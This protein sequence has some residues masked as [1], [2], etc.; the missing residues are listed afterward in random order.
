M[1][2]TLPKE[3]HPLCGRS[4]LQHVINAARSIEPAQLLVVLSP[5]KAVVTES[6]PPG[7]E[8]A[9]QAEPLGT[10]HA[11][12]QALPLLAPSI[13]RV[14]ILYGDHPLLTGEAVA[15][16]VDSACRS[17]ALITLLTAVLPDPGAYGRVHYEGERVVGVIEAKDDTRLFSEP[18]EINSGI[19]CFD[20]DWLTRRLPDV[21]R[22]A[23]GEYYLTSLIE[24]AAHEET[25]SR[26]VVP[27]VVAP[28]VAFGVN[29]RVELARAEQLL[30]KRVNERLM[31]SGVTIVDPVTT[32]IDDE[33]E[34]GQDARI[35]PFTMISGE[36]RIGERTVIGPSAHIQ[37]TAIG[38]DCVILAS[39]LESSTI[40]DR[41]HVGPYSHFRAGTR[42]AADVHIGNYVE[43][44]SSS[45][46]SGT[47]IGHFSYI[48]DAEIGRNVNIAAGTITANY[49]GI[50]KHRTVI[51]DDAFIGCDTI[52]RAPVTVG[53]AGRTG[54]G[55]VVT[56]DVSPGVTVV[57]LPARPI[58]S[59]S[60][61]GRQ[62]E[63][64]E[65]E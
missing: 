62:L 18:V 15:A 40:G 25:P 24:L 1:R 65:H 44:K 61:A 30:R 13:T 20:R 11:V 49:D 10:G 38:S 54:A 26:P 52:L 36:S 23:S 43:I 6:L 34:I 63:K 21:P 56:R 8:V 28:E 7:C 57:G 29:D 33:V 58:A 5:A 55:S 27:I 22:S 48:G 37:Q 53:Y 35:E 16:L 47:H 60:G 41:V 3:L 14:A 31:L 4:M 59:K 42:I 50:N 19:S 39:T 46:G 64:Q 45:V 12:A 51:E 9:W 2:S 32:F 17:D